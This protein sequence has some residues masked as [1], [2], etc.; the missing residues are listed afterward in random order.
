MI[1]PSKARAQRAEA[2]KVRAEEEKVQAEKVQAEK[3]RR[4][5][6]KVRR[7]AEKVQAE[8]KLV[9]GNWLYIHVPKTGGCSIESYLAHKYNMSIYVFLSNVE[10]D[11]TLSTCS[12]Q[13]YTLLLKLAYAKMKGIILDDSVNYFGSVRNPYTRAVSDLY[14]YKLITH[15]SSPIDVEKQLKTYINQYMINHE[16]YD[17]HV[18]PQYLFFVNNEGVMDSR[19]KIIKQETLCDDMCSLGFSDFKIEVNVNLHKGNYYKQLTMNAV[20]MLNNIYKEDF[21]LF[22]YSMIHSEEELTA[23]Q[24]LDT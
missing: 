20:H 3:V 14:Y 6:E 22:N 16:A 4:E 17:N 10:H 7:E 2:E 12:K 1:S 21:T 15:T 11:I 19:V 23:L 18:K 8:N 5:A 24:K 9:A 13:H